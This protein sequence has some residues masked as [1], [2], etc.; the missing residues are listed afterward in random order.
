MANFL[1][2]R[3]ARKKVAQEQ[4]RSTKGASSGKAAGSSTLSDSR[5]ETAG[6]VMDNV[7]LTSICRELLNLFAA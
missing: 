2:E 3:N 4:R 7:V 5:A 6:V 1:A